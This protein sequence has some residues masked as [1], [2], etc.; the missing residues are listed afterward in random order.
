MLIYAVDVFFVA[1]LGAF[2]LAASSLAI[3]LLSIIIWAL[4]GL[5]GMVSALIAAELGRN[6]YAVAEVRRSDPHGTMGGGG[7]RPPRHA[8]AVAGRPMC[9]A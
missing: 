9:C 1:R 8:A 7:G 6:R 2:E 5:V 4:I 3:S